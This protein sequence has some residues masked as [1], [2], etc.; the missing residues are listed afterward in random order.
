MAVDTTETPAV[1]EEATEPAGREKSGSLTDMLTNMVCCSTESKTMDAP[2]PESIDGD[3]PEV[4]E[5]EETEVWTRKGKEEPEP[6]PEPAPEPPAE[7]E[8]E[9]EPA[10]APE[11]EPEP[12]PA[13]EPEPEP[14]PAEEPEVPA[15]AP[16]RRAS[17]APAAPAPKKRMSILEAMQT[18]VASALA[19]G[20]DTDEA[21]VFESV[22]AKKGSG[23]TLGSVFGG[24]SS[25]WKNRKFELVKH[26]RDDA[27]V[28][29]GPVLRYYDASG[30]HF[31]G[32]VLL[33]GCTVAANAKRGSSTQFVFEVA[34]DARRNY[35]LAAD[36]DALRGAWIDALDREIGGHAKTLEALA[37][38]EKKKRRASIQTA[39]AATDKE[40]AGDDTA[41]ALEG[42][43]HY[44][45]PCKS[46]LGK[47]KLA[48]K[49]L[50]FELVHDADAGPMIQ[51]TTKGTTCQIV[52]EGC[53]CLKDDSVAKEVMTNKAH[54]F[55]VNHE[56]FT[57]P[58][59]FYAGSVVV[60]TRWVD[61]IAAAVADY[62]ATAPPEKKETAKKARR[63]SMALEATVVNDEDEA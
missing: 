61:A 52:L 35:V 34:S 48:W 60:R 53:D 16:A 58:K 4:E 8:P 11:P 32:A 12:E 29:V 17:M 21:V 7:P 1:G 24:K 5:P 44:K 14:A 10:A 38:A 18:S 39:K 22:L 43:L 13:A 26:C 50:H 46:L 3:V 47:E 42:E 56:S 31:K 33:D 62:G 6:A 59:C 20:E 41:P 25:G 40:A 57:T 23:S 9:P 36:N 27:G 45:T 55:Y 2:E 19:I 51:W 30:A 54:G 28:D 15:P 37:P 63:A 49:K